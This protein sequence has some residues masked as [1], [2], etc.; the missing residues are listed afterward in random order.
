MEINETTILDDR[1]FVK[2]NGD[3]AKSFLQNIVTNDIEVINL[4]GSP[5]LDTMQKVVIDFPKME[6]P[7]LA[8]IAVRA[9][10]LCGT[11]C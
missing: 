10:G 6:A 5:A 9:F 1:G 4:D 8:G 2:I 7:K 3:E 11:S